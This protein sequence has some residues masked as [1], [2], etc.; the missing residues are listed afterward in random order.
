MK[1]VSTLTREPERLA[2]LYSHL[3][4][5]AAGLPNDELFAKMI[6]SQMVGDGALPPGLGLGAEGYARLLV[7]HFPG[8]DL[9]PLIEADV[10]P[11]A[12]RRDERQDLVI[13]MSEHRAGHD[14]SELWMA[15]IVAAACMGG[16]H[17]W[18]DLG[19]WNR[20]DLTRLMRENF[21]ALAAKNVHDMK[22]KK[23]LYKQLCQQEGMYVCRSPSCEVCVDYQDCFG[24]ED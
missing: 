12:E 18:Q 2:G 19:L 23:F 14:P 11:A 21:P 16:D 20:A 13:L 4:L 5:H 1:H 7:R 3:M 24:P 9:T 15:E 6:A 22:W 17:L 8:S 10:P